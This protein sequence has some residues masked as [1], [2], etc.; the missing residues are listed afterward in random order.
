MPSRVQK[1]G[2]AW[3]VVV[4]RPDGTERPIPCVKVFGEVTK[5]KVSLMREICDAV[6]AEQGAKRE[7]TRKEI[8]PKGCSNC[9]TYAPLLA[10]L[11]GGSLGLTTGVIRVA[12][13]RV[14]ST[15]EE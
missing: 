2:A 4:K 5:E 15:Q 6:V 12:I 14:L 11:R 10:A 8:K 1:K 3:Y 13:E 9:E 7:R